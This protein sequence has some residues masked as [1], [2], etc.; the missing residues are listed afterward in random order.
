MNFYCDFLLINCLCQFFGNKI[1]LSRIFILSTRF[2]T[3]LQP[4]SQFCFVSLSL[5]TATVLQNDNNPTRSVTV[6]QINTYSRTT[7]ACMYSMLQL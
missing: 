1:Y 7:I 4:T 5:C 6:S 3:L 2:V